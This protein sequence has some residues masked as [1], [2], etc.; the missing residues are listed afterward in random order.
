MKGKTLG[1]IGAAVTAL[2]MLGTMTAF[3]D[4]P[5]IKDKENGTSYNETT[6]T[7]TVAYDGASTTGDSTFLIWDATAI[8]EA[9]N[10]ETTRYDGNGSDVFYVD[11][12]DLKASASGSVAFPLSAKAKGTEEAPVYKVII[13]MGGVGKTAAVSL[14]ELRKPVYKVTA[15]ETMQWTQ[16]ADVT[17]LAGKK[18][19]VAVTTVAEITDK[20]DALNLPTT[21]KADTTDT[22]HAKVDLPITNW[23]IAINDTATGA[24]LTPVVN[25]GDYVLNND[26]VVPAPLNV[27][28]TNVANVKETVTWAASLS[29][30]R[31]VAINARDKENVINELKTNRVQT[32]GAENVEFGSK[33][34]PVTVSFNWASDDYDAATPGSYTFTATEAIVTSANA[35]EGTTIN[36][37]AALTA[38]LPQV[39]VTVENKTPVSID[40]VAFKDVTGAD[41]DGN[42]TL[43]D[44]VARG[45]ALTAITGLPTKFVI[46]HL[47]DGANTPA[48]IPN[49]E[50]DISNWTCA[51]YNAN[52]ENDTE[53]TLVPTASIAGQD[54]SHVYSLASG[55]TL[56]T[57]KVTVQGWPTIT[58]FE[59]S[60]ITQELNVT[61][62]SDDA[63][64]IKSGHENF[65]TQL[66]VSALA[67]NEQVPA[68]LKASV[69]W[70]FSSY[71]ADEAGTY[72]ITANVTPPA[73]YK[74]TIDPITV[75]VKVASAAVNLKYGDVDGS[76]RVDGNDAAK[77]WQLFRKKTDEATLLNTYNAN[78]AKRGEAP[79]DVDALKVIMN[80]DNTNARI[81]GNDA[82][83]IW[84][85]F[86]KKIDSLPV[87]PVQ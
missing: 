79:I 78:A 75:T 46:A 8:A 43:A 53:Y 7:L 29:A 30:P 65:P 67:D 5:T 27:A 41:A 81:D 11:Q 63:K 52:P 72:T 14:F 28:F 40:K 2:S 15:F 49:L 54:D 77:V 3:A 45:T 31:S 25:L 61:A 86:R 6:N 37:P 38:A 59:V 20:K 70:D 62:G 48:D 58:A 26:N 57:V 10:P 18:G 47:V 32:I 13:G 87:K 51:T 83:K 71:K 56:P 39:T 82:A 80:A 84:Q 21:I 12:R 64:A 33:V 74:M 73:N 23:N 1:R 4:A 16:P 60:G 50:F 34:A 44:K 66:A 42:I 9:F 36:L 76:G 35:P 24:T 68:D 19:D 22:A 85:F 55:V 69:V 17:F